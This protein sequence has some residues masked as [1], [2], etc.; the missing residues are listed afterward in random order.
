M[1]GAIT[2]AAVDPENVLRPLSIFGGHAAQGKDIAA[3]RRHRKRSKRV[4][5]GEASIN[6]RLHAIWLNSLQASQTFFLDWPPLDSDPGVDS[7]SLSDPHS[8]G[9]RTIPGIAAA[10]FR[11]YASPCMHEI[12]SVLNAMPRHNGGP[13]I[14]PLVR[15]RGLIATG[16][17]HSWLREMPHQEYHRRMLS[18]AGAG[19]KPEAQRVFQRRQSRRSPPNQGFHRSLLAESNRKGTRRRRG[20]TI[21][22]PCTGYER[23]SQSPGGPAFDV[24]REGPK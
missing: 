5:D 12:R 20:E 4:H 22:T 8:P 23:R 21:C 24:N 7:N 1:I 15:F 3:G 18:P 11:A 17:R 6:S 16:A 14:V 13:C 2:F 19:Y 10:Y 9:N